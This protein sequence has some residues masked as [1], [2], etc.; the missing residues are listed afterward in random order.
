MSRAKILYSV[1][2]LAVLGALVSEQLANEELIDPSWSCDLSSRCIQWVLVWCKKVKGWYAKPKRERW[3]LTKI[4]SFCRLNLKKNH[5]NTDQW[6]KPKFSML[7]YSAFVELNVSCFVPLHIWSFRFDSFESSF[8]P[9]LLCSKASVWFWNEHFDAF[10]DP[11]FLVEKKKSV[12]NFCPACS[13]FV[14]WLSYW[15]SNLS[16]M[17]LYKWGASALPNSISFR[18]NVYYNW[19]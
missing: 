6:L 8:P 13:F 10:A 17:T 9:F 12:Y 2:I 11:K 5:L 3:K 7:Q 19:V 4:A 1:R 15:S 14:T 16:C 18:N